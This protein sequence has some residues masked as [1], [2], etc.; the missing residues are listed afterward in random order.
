MIQE[1]LTIWS[2]DPLPFLNPTWTSGSSRF[3]YCCSLAW[4]ILS[5]ILL[6]CE[7]S[8]KLWNSLNVLCYCLSLGLEWNLKFSSPVATAEFPNLLAYECSTFTAS[9]SRI[10]D[11]STGILSPLLALF[12]VTLPKARLTLHF[13]MSG[14]SWLITPHYGYGSLRPFLYSSSVYSWHLF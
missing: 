14:S 3:M 2:L 12:I 10:L 8:A 11:N 5:I 4:R 9:S 13:R 6:A 7:M 1:M